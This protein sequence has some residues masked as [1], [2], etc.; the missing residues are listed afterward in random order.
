MPVDVPCV[1]N[2]IGLLIDVISVFRA[3]NIRLLAVSG[4]KRSMHYVTHNSF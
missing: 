4:Q 2:Q 1:S 3:K